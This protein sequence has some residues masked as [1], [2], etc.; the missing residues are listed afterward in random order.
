MTKRRPWYPFH[1][2]EH[3]LETKHISDAADLLY[4]RMLSAL[5]R[6]GG[7][8]LLDY[9]LIGREVRKRPSF[10]RK[11]FES[12]LRRF[13]T[14]KG[15]EFYHIRILEEYNKAVEISQKRHNAANARHE[16]DE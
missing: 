6:N 11:V 15:G 10:V 9:E 8:M 12:E 2:E 16:G 5:W 7:V 3:E 13:F 1:Y 4:R 14:V